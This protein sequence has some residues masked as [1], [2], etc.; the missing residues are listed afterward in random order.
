MMGNI[1]PYFSDLLIAVNVCVVA[2]GPTV[3]SQ[4]VPCGGRLR[5]ERQRRREEQGRARQSTEGNFNSI[6][7]ISYLFQHYSVTRLNILRASSLPT[8]WHKYS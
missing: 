1:V 7:F 4:G 3:R 8:F 6:W 2:A 5:R